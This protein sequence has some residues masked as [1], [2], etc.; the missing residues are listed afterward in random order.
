MDLRI[1]DN[2][3]I[4]GIGMIIFVNFLGVRAGGQIARAN[5]FYENIKH[6]KNITVVIIKQYK[7]L[8]KI[9]SNKVCEVIDINFY[10]LNS[11]FVINFIFEC[12]R[13]KKYLN[14][15]NPNIY[16]S[17]SNILPFFL[18]KK[19]KTIIAISNLAPFSH[20]SLKNA[21]F[22]M[23]FRMF[24]KKI[25]ILSSSSRADSVLALSKLC[26]N[27]LEQHGV[28][29]NKIFVASNGVDSFWSKVDKNKIVEVDKKIEFILYVSHF[30]FYKNHFRLLKAYALFTK[31]YKN[32]IKLL[33]IGNAP[34]EI[35]FNK[36]KALIKELNINEKVLIKSVNDNNRLRRYYQDATFFIFPSLIENSP[37]ILIEAMMSKC[38]ILASNCEPMP[39][40]G[41][42]AI[43]YFDPFDHHDIFKKIEEK[44]LNG[45][46]TNKKNYL[47]YEIAK[48]YNWQDFTNC[49]IEKAYELN[50]I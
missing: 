38:D 16:L 46:Q 27:I 36:V 39:E 50:K 24:I 34:D 33:L 7:S 10:P 21:N 11:N 19:I 37:N 30:H 8:E 13:I 42:N 15:Y 3:N 2:N 41:K 47:A 5:A 12:C 32:D 18:P 45:S 48:K 20:A 1:I 6:K 43:E 25:M 26:M 44:F 9:K 23:K 4:K 29:K 14:F 40:F 31:K 22:L 17:F 35:Y 49:I 28:E